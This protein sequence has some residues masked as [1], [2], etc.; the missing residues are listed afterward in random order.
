MRDQAKPKTT[1]PFHSIGLN[2]DADESYA[3]HVAFGN[4]LIAGSFV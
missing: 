1:N 3:L 2:W 4:I